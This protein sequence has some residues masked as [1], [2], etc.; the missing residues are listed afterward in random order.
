MNFTPTFRLLAN[1][2]DVSTHIQKNLITLSFK[3]EA[4]VLSDEI[5]LE[6]AGEFKRPKYQDKLKLWLGYKESG[7]WY[8]GSFLVQ[9]SQRTQHSTTITATGVDFSG[10]LKEK[11]NRSWEKLSLKEIIEKIAKEHQLGFQSDFEDV[12]LLYLAQ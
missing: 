8:C 12:K 3:D 6:V 10:S 4:G 9:S 7:L 2:K 5:T 1:D 11:R